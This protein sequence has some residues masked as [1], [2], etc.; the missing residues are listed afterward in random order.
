MG[1]GKRKW[2][3]LF[4][5]GGQ[6]AAG[7]LVASVLV[8]EDVVAGLE[9]RRHQRFDGARHGVDDAE[10]AAEGAGLAQHPLDALLA[11]QRREHH[12]GEAFDLF[13]RQ[14][15]RRRAGPRRRRL[16]LAVS[17][18]VSLASLAEEVVF[19]GRVGRVGRVHFGTAVGS[20]VGIVVRIAFFFLEF[21]EERRKEEGEQLGQL[22]LQPVA[23]AAAAAA[24]AA[25]G[26]HRDDRHDDGQQ[27]QQRNESD[28]RQAQ[29]ALLDA[30]EEA[31]LVRLAA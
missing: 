1:G 9:R 18:A 15:G 29:Q 2:A 16:S 28:Q 22:P 6:I 20:V 23:G 3:G 12:R 17:L 7:E 21:D 8:G 14:D 27:R 5:L 26:H 31:L 30:D 11:T 4:L 24:A 19:V 25:E 13:G 10:G